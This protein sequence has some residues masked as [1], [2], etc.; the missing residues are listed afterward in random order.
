MFKKILP[1][2]IIITYTYILFACGA[3][4][5]NIAN[6]NTSSQNTQ[7]QEAA[8]LLRIA[9]ENEDISSC[10]NLGYMYANGDGVAE[11]AQEAVRLFRLACDGGEM[12]GCF[13]L[14]ILCRSQPN[15]RGCSN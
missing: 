5:A 8:R 6:E 14:G 9:C 10:F 1:F 11:D 3:N 7:K 2:F 15:L 4:S 13:N 12:V